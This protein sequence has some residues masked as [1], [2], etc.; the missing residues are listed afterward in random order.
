MKIPVPDR[1]IAPPQEPAAP[2]D[3]AMAMER[4]QRLLKLRADQLQQPRYDD[5]G[6]VAIEAVQDPKEAAK[7]ARK[8]FVGFVSANPDARGQ[9]RDYLTGKRTDYPE[10]WYLDE[11]ALPSKESMGAAGVMR[12][13]EEGR[14]RNPLA[15]AALDY[16]VLPALS[17]YTGTAQAITDIT[18][19]GAN[20][21]GANVEPRDVKAEAIAKIQQ[22]LGIGSGNAKEISAQLQA[23]RETA[24]LPARIVGMYGDVKGA[25]KGCRASQ[26]ALRWPPRQRSLEVLPSSAALV[27][28]LRASLVRWVAL[29]ATKH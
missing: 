6:R 27:R 12:Q 24:S 13:A 1:P 8:A 15:A 22:L 3:V 16:V 5:M 11:S 2:P 26:R 21:L 18:E 29:R 9:I 28:R 17:I 4:F 19:G 23:M 25:I 10:G 14:K 20:V 7:I